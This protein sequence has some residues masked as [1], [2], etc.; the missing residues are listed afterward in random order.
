[1]D[2]DTYEHGVPSWVDLGTP[3]PAAA[4]EFYS[5][6][7]GWDVQ[8]GPPE[9]GGYAMCY[10]RGR[11]VAGLGPQQSPDRRCGRPTSTSTTP[12]QPPPR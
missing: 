6:L 7:F 10:L 3:D 9:T 12:T 11:M 4:G 8:P 2:I 5:A 1:M